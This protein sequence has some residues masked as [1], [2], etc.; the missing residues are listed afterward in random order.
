MTNKH[1]GVKVQLDTEAVRDN[2]NAGE[3]RSRRFCFDFCYIFKISVRKIVRTCSSRLD[4]QGS[5]LRAL[6]HLKVKLYSIA[7]YRYWNDFTR[8]L[9]FHS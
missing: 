1:L 5:Q 8:S 9:Y 3:V 7:I 4:A 6:A 2:V